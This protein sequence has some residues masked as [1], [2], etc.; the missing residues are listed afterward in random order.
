M[1]ELV[2]PRRNIWVGAGKFDFLFKM[3]CIMLE[4]I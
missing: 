2:A 4:S 3:V 1:V